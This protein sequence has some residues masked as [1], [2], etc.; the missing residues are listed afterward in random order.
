M[1]ILQVC[2]KEL[3]NKWAC[4]THV[5]TVHMKQKNA[6]CPKFPKCDMA[7]YSYD[8][9]NKHVAKEHP[10]LVK[11]PE[12]LAPKVCTICGLQVHILISLK[13]L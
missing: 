2:G 5:Q 8:A 13:D 10:E 1:S 6:K 7:F 11:E 4:Q 3:V 9:R 12:K